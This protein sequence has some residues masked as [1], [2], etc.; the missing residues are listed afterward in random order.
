MCSHPSQSCHTRV[1]DECNWKCRHQYHTSCKGSVVSSL[2]RRRT[3]LLT[4]Q[5]SLFVFA[6]CWRG[7]R[8]PRF[9]LYVASH[10]LEDWS[11]VTCGSVLHQPEVYILL[12]NKG[13]ARRAMKKHRSASHL[14]HA[15]S[16]RGI[17]T[18]RPRILI[19]N[20]A[21]CMY[22]AS[23]TCIRQCDRCGTAHIRR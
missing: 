15:Q 21:F 22:M 20:Q 13:R 7:S 17:W 18:V 3:W 14:S 4:V 16:C 11:P 12:S 5:S 6:G 8:R 1:A 19:G 2:S 9:M 10:P 23:S